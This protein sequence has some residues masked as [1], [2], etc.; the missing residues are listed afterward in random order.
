MVSQLNCKQ[1][2][3]NLSSSR[4]KGVTQHDM[5]A[6]MSMLLT[7]PRPSISFDARIKIQ[8]TCVSPLVQLREKNKKGSGFLYSILVL[9][10]FCF[11]CPF[12][13][14]HERKRGC[15]KGKGGRIVNGE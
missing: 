3:Q 7:N 1:Q 9:I 6:A 11:L 15:G 13:S 5:C 12:D 2:Q 10:F 4:A 14:E 8:L